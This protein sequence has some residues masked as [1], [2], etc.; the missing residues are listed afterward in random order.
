MAIVRNAKKKDFDYY[1][2]NL[3]WGDGSPIERDE[4]LF[5]RN[6]V[7]EHNYDKPGFYSIKG[8]VFKFE[9]VTVNASPPENLDMTLD[10]ED[11]TTT[12]SDN[13]PAAGETKRYV[14]SKENITQ[15]SS[16]LSDIMPSAG[17][18]RFKIDESYRGTNPVHIGTT[19]YISENNLP[20]SWVNTVVAPIEKRDEGRL[21]GI[22]IPIRIRQDISNIDRIYYSLEINLANPNGEDNPSQYVFL[23]ESYPIKIDSVDDDDE[24]TSTSADTETKFQTVKYIMGV[25]GN[26]TGANR[27]GDV[28]NGGWQKIT[29]NIFV[30]EPENYI[31]SNGN[32]TSNLPNQIYGS[33]ITV[34]PRYPYHTPQDENITAFIG[35]RNLVIKTPNTE[36]IIRPVEWQRFYS[37]IM[38]NPR[39]DYQSPLYEL[40]DFAMIGGVSEKSSH[41]KTLTSLAAFDLNDKEY[42]NNSLVSS[43]N[44]YDFI[45]I[46][47]TM[48]KYNSDYYNEV[49][50][51]YTNPIHEDYAPYW[52]D[53]NG[54]IKSLFDK[55]KIHNGFVDTNYHG[56]LEDTE[57][58]DID[59]STTKVHKGV[60]PLWK[61]IGVQEE[62]NIPNEQIYWKN[63]IPKD[64]KLTDRGG[65]SKEPLEDPTK[66]SITPRIPRLVWIIDEENDQ[67]WNGDY[68]WPNLPKMT[69]GGVFAESVDLDQYGDGIITSDNP[70]DETLFNLVFDVDDVEELLDTTTNYNIEYRVDGILDLDENNRVDILTN[71]ISDTLENDINK[72]AF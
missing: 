27:D 58:T 57:I 46:Y 68:Y 50:D 36:N 67:N 29:G 2:T 40:N 22:E 60:I 20:P 63:I 39:D 55:K 8:L 71:D 13:H 11:R 3:D 72:Q 37:N 42:K 4:K 26:S 23:E 52:R 7:F 45:S 38:V 66:G 9:R 31:D 56:V 21:P 34:Y 15:L 61:Q 64:Y 6:Y 18:F 32:D 54:E 17:V 44:P 12:Y 5:T 24:P 41:F 1:L 47:D 19:E 51:P 53:D 33:K 10:Y 65:F 28:K 49:L 69:R 70:I 30:Q 59:V 43:Y 16:S 14:R 62:N 35:I 25:G 48:V